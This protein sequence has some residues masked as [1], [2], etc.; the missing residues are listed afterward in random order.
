MRNTM[1]NAG[2][3]TQENQSIEIFDI[4][5]IINKDRI[6]I[7]LSKDSSNDLNFQDQLLLQEQ[8]IKLIFKIN[9]LIPINDFIKHRFS[10]LGFTM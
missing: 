2:F 1:H 4:Y 10:D 9:L 3:Q 8:I 5:S 6:V 7:K